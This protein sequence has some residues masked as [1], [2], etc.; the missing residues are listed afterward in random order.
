MIKNTL[1]LFSVITALGVSLLAADSGIPRVALKEAI[2]LAEDCLSTNSV[3]TSKHYLSGATLGRYPG[4]LNY[5]DLDWSPA[6]KAA[7][8]GVIYVRIDMDQTVKI[9][10]DTYRFRPGSIEFRPRGT[11]RPT[12]T[13]WMKIEDKKIPGDYFVLVK[14]V[15]DTDADRIRERV[16]D[17]MEK[18]AGYV[19]VIAWPLSDGFARDPETGATPTRIGG[20]LKTVPEDDDK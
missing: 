4:G 10:A 6:D 1:V 9:T 13:V 2:S 17:M 19:T 14:R 5:W 3:D 15:L 11:R 18:D 12:F 8:S 16:R 20:R 7:R